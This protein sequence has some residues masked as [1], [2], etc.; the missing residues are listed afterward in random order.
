MNLN[1]LLLVAAAGAAL[2]VTGCGSSDEKDTPTKTTAATT[3]AAVPSKPPAAAAGLSGC[4][5]EKGIESKDDPNNLTLV[6]LDGQIPKPK[7]TLL[8]T[9]PEKAGG[10]EVNLFEFASEGDA[11]KALDGIKS[12]ESEV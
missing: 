12:Q 7:S 1:R 11:A 5:S 4:L 10:A 6:Y 3:T 2:A 8:L 9:Y